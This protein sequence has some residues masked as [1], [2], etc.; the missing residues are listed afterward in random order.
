MI[1]NGTYKA[2]GVEAALGKASTG[3]HEV[4]VLLEVTSGDHAGTRLTWHGY[5]TEKTT[6]RT[7]ESLRYLGWE[8]DDLSKLEG[9]SANEVS[10]VVERETYEDRDGV[11]QERAKVRWINGAGGV[12]IKDRLDDADAIAFAQR[13][14]GHVVAH[15]TKNKTAPAPRNANPPARRPDPGGFPGDDVPF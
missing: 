4:A 1:P 12:A 8:G 15:R 5:F 6:D 2:K 13:M 3:T 7:L 10:I 9:I 11:T 14:K